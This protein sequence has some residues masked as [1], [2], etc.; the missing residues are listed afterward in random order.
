MQPPTAGDGAGLELEPTSHGLH[1]AVLG[2]L[3]NLSSSVA[4]RGVLS[5]VVAALPQPD[6]RLD[7][8]WGPTMARRVLRELVGNRDD[9]ATEGHSNIERSNV[10]RLKV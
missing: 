8:V 9:A 5:L 1:R 6:S 3:E 10:G 4:G 2:S 7:R